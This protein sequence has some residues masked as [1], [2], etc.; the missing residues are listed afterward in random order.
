MQVHLRPALSIKKMFLIRG[1]NM[2]NT[3]CIPG[4]RCFIFL[5]LV[6]CSCEEDYE[7]QHWKSIAGEV[8]HKL[9]LGFSPA[10]QDSVGY[11][12]LSKQLFGS[13]FLHRLEDS[14]LRFFIFVTLSSVCLPI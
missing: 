4:D 6:A 3:P 7:K 12:K 11:P 1:F 13:P 14:L 9:T 8:L 2:R 10:Y 5:D